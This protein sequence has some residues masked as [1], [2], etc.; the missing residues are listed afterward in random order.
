MA[1]Q[2]IYAVTDIE[3]GEPLALVQASTKAQALAHYAKR[4]LGCAVAIP[5]QLIEA[6]KLGIDVEKA[7]E[8]AGE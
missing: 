4:T 1:A 8:E 2:R 3:T 7:G 5:E 6:T